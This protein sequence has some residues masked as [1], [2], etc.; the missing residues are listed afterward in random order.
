MQGQSSYPIYSKE[1]VILK[2]KNEKQ[3]IFT[4]LILFISKIC[5]SQKFRRI[6]NDVKF[7]KFKGKHP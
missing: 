1:T 7:Q 6:W 4:K 2:A 5:T 3:V